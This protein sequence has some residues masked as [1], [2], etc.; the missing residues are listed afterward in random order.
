MVPAALPRSTLTA[1]SGAQSVRK[2]LKV[3]GR[4]TANIQ[5]ALSRTQVG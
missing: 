2:N 4:M 3:K 1:G 5:Q